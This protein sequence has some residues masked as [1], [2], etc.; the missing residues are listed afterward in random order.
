M[1]KILFALSLFLIG[2]SV[3]AQALPQTSTSVM[4]NVGDPSWATFD[5]SKVPNNIRVVYQCR[6]ARG[7]YYT[8]F[9]TQAQ[10]ETQFDIGCTSSVSHNAE[11]QRVVGF[12]VNKT[13]FSFDAVIQSQTITITGASWKSTE[14]GCGRS[15]SPCFK[16]AVGSTT[17]T[18]Q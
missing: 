12:T 14:V 11:G 15:G 13:P 6:F 17:I 3:H 7:F 4:V 10:L 8:N 2:L 16:D 5:F 1:R 9:D 18:V